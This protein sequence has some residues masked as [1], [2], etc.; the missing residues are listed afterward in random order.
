VPAEEH[1]QQPT[2]ARVLSLLAAVVEKDGKTAAGVLESVCQEGQAVKG[3]VL[4]DRS[5]EGG[6]RAGVPGH[7][8]PRRLH[9]V[10]RIADDVAQ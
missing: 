8:V 10:E 1:V 2:T 3:P 4:I 5:G 6:N 9:G 7:P